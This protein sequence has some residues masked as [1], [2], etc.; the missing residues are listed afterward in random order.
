MKEAG[1]RV[2]ELER[3]LHGKVARNRCYS[4]M[5]VT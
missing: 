4:E 5:E 3:A 1:S 2:C